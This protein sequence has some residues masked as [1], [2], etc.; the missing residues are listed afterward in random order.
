MNIPCYGSLQ[1]VHATGTKIIKE[2]NC[3]HKTLRDNAVTV[4]SLMLATT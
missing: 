4:V 3:Y 2:H 1:T